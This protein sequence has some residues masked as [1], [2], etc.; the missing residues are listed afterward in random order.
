MVVQLK[1]KFI[2]GA[3]NACYSSVLES[4]FF[5]GKWDV[6]CCNVPE[7]SIEF[8]VRNSSQML[9]YHILHFSIKDNRNIHVCAC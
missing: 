4:L 6:T 8:L 2:P 7:L 5:L 1:V 9:F 3:M